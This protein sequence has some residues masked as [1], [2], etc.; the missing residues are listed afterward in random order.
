MRVVRNCGREVFCRLCVLAD[1][2]KQ[3]SE[4]ELNG[5]RMREEAGQRAELPERPY[6]VRLREQ[7]DRGERPR[8]RIVR[9]E[10]RGGRELP[11]GGDRA[12]QVPE[13]GAVHELRAWV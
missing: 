2:E 10:L 7:P 3:H 8:E 11:L 1:L 4:V 12:A 5:R 6:R 9:R 13:R